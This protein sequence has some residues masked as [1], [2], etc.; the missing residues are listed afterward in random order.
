MYI[1]F[2]HVLLDALKYLSKPR[3]IITSQLS[4]LTSQHKSVCC[5]ALTALGPNTA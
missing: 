1:A 4:T 2:V 5:V 3:P